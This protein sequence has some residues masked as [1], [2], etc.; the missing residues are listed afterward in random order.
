MKIRYSYHALLR[1]GERGISKK[2]I[3]IAIVLGVKDDAPG[4]IRVALHQTKHRALTVKY[5][6]ISELEIK[7]ITTYY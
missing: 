1:M 7:V 6:I 3:E 5:R 2:E 4:G